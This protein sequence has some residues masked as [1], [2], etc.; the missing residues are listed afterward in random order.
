M[1]GEKIINKIKT[2]KDYGLA[3]NLYKENEKET[4]YILNRENYRIKIII[5][6][7]RWLGLEFS[8]LDKTGKEMLTY[9]IDT[10]LYNI[11]EGRYTLFSEEIESEIVEFLDILSQHK[12]KVGKIRGKP[13][14]IIPKR[15]KFLLI[16]KGWFFTSTKLYPN[17][18]AAIGGGEFKDL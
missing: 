11:S 18:K 12:I 17:V 6:P 8:L 9:E 4:I 10:D 13:A 14:V 15:D 7:K 5:E 1:A 2:L 16:K 3:I